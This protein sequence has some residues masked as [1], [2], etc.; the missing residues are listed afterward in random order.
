MIET[1][2]VKIRENFRKSNRPSRLGGGGWEATSRGWLSWQINQPWAGIN[3][4]QLLQFRCVCVRASKCAS[5]HTHTHTHT[6]SFSAKVD[7]VYSYSHGPLAFS[8]YAATICPT[9]GE[10]ENNFVQND[11]AMLRMQ[12]RNFFDLLQL[13]RCSLQSWANA[14]RLVWS[15][16]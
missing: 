1:P 10:R 6:P 9:G 16:Q 11:S 3:P 7:R 12:A 8:T 15:Q 4:W 14:D 2:G 13:L 5:T